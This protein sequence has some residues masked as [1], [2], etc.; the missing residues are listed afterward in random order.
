MSRRFLGIILLFIGSLALTAGSIHLLL[1]N[2]TIPA[3]P[4]VTATE[5]YFVPPDCINK[6]MSEA[7]GFEFCYP[8]SWKLGEFGEKK[9]IVAIDA[10]SSPDPRGSLGLIQI[11]VLE[12]RSADLLFSLRTMLKNDHEER[13]TLAGLDG[14]RIAGEV[15]GKLHTSV[16]VTK[17]KNTYEISIQGHPVEYQKYLPVY[18]NLLSFW[19]WK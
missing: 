12:G 15:R 10:K 6:Y 1:T 17:G 8:T 7:F 5:N 11:T 3:S 13:E 19:Q 18:E 9:E 14:T 2:N 4:P 16:V